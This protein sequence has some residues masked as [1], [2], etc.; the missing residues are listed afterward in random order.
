MEPVGDGTRWI[1][2]LAALTT[3]LD[4]DL[5]AVE[6]TLVQISVSLNQYVSVRHASRAV[7]ERAFARRQDCM[8]TVPVDIMISTMCVA[9]VFVRVVFLFDNPLS[10]DANLGG[11]VALQRVLHD[12]GFDTDLHLDIVGA[13]S[14]T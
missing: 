4:G 14:S 9:L 7:T 10:D 2:E 11:I 5:S 3:A 1:V 6:A 13:R 8:C 12:G